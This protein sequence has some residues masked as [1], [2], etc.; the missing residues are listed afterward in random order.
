MQYR[1]PPNAAN[2][3]IKVR[4]GHL[5]ISPGATF[6]FQEDRLVQEIQVRQKSSE[7]SQGA[8]LVRAKFPD[9]KH[10]GSTI[11]LVHS[12]HCF[13]GQILIVRKPAHVA[14]VAT[15]GKANGGGGTKLVFGAHFVLRKKRHGHN[16]KT[17]SVKI[18]K[19]VAFGTNNFDLRGEFHEYGLRW[20]GTKLRWYFDNM[21]YYEMSLDPDY[22]N[23][24]KAMRRSNWCFQNGLF[25]VPMKLLVDLDV[26]PGFNQSAEENGN[27]D[28]EKLLIDWVKVYEFP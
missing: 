21:Q 10:L 11:R 26:Y 19:N 24:K 25:S 15:T 1:P 4:N 12:S 2:E 14:A 9:G 7:F 20:T 23:T 22:W 27:S 17:S 6:D 3:K 8:F 18:V 5:E 28:S 13:C 16:N